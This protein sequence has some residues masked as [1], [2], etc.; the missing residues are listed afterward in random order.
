MKT[1]VEQT[2]FGEDERNSFTLVTN[3]ERVKAPGIPEIKATPKMSA[4]SFFLSF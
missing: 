4:V 2:R 1:R 3:S